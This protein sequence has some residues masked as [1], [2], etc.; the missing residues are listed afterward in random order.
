MKYRKS[1]WSINCRRRK[2]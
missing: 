1:Y 2:K